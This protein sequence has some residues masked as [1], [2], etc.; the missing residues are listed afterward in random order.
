MKKL[1]LRILVVDDNQELAES[2]AEVLEARC[3]QGEVAFSGEE[4]VRK[5]AEQEFDLTFMDVK[6]AGMNGVEAFFEILKLKP[7]AQVIMVTAFSVE[8]LLQQAVDKGAAGVLHKPFNR[9]KLHSLLGAAQSRMTPPAAN[10]SS[11]TGH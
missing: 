6:M 5:F 10:R 2:L 9:N 7:N 8:H 11:V 1:K 4:A 3:Y